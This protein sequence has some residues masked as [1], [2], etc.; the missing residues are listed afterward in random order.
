MFAACSEAE[1]HALEL[2]HVGDRQRRTARRRRERRRAVGM[3][4]HVGDAHVAVEVLVGDDVVVELGGL[5]A[6]E[7]DGIGQQLGGEVGGVGEADVAAD[8]QHVGVGHGDRAAEGHHVA[9]DRGAR[10]RVGAVGGAHQVAEGVERDVDHVERA[11]RCARREVQDRRHVLAGAGAEAGIGLGVGDRAAE[12]ARRLAPPAELRDVL[13]VDDAAGDG[14]DASPGVSV[15]SRTG[16]WRRTA[17]R[18]CAR[19]RRP[20]A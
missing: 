10:H 8:K 17:R 16:R 15:R 18:G 9:E 3:D 12:L 6:G 1:R 14:R 5:R 2:G 19:C 13:G 4:V 7:G 20:P 11:A